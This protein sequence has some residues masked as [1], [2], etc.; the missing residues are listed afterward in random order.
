MRTIDGVLISANHQPGPTELA[1]VIAH[2][3]T[4]SWRR[5]AV[6]RAAD[7]FNRGAGVISF[8]FRG[9]GRSG[10]SSTVGDQEIHDLEAAVAWAR[11]LGY[12]EIVTI[13]FS[14][15]ASVVVRHAALVRGVAAA[16]AVSS[17]A[18]W[19]YRGTTPM[20]RVHWVIERRL[21]RLLG[22]VAL[23]TRISGRGW[24]PVPE[25]PTEVVARIAPTPLLVVHGDA[26]TYFP[27]EHAYSLFAAANDP[28]S[29]WIE[30][31][32][33]HAENAATEELLER[34]ADWIDRA[35]GITRP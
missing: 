23:R 8:D 2:G 19:Y 31:E 14:M 7:V 6:R 22:R 3:F 20:R 10:G 30:R 11:E 4:G 25:S 26:D 33:G 24:N 27:V 32:F 18:R 35:V 16:V 21:G 12:K 15:G 13:G 5:P 28:R 1:L 34:I 29:I 17:P 9:H